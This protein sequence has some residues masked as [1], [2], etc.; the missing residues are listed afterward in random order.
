MSGSGKQILNRI[1]ADLSTRFIESGELQSATKKLRAGL[2][3]HGSTSDE[4][5]ALVNHLVWA[6]SS[7]EDGVCRQGMAVDEGSVFVSDMFESIVDL[8]GLKNAMLEKHSNLT[9]EGYDAGVFSIWAVLSSVQ[10]FS[11]LLEVEKGDVDVDG[12]VKSMNRH[13]E[14][15]LARQSS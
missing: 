15:Y 5:F 10:M 9:S 8:P 2:L 1:L 12:R 7:D 13:M 14:D 4:N 6:S 3:L 11:S